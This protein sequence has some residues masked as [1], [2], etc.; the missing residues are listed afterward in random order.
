MRTI[1]LGLRASRG[2]A[3]VVAVDVERDAPHVALSSFIPTATENDRLAS[4]PYHVAAEIA[5]DLSEH[6]FVEAAAAVREGR[7][8]QDTFAA[9]GLRSVVEQ[10][11]DGGFDAVGAAL[12]VNRAGWVTDL[13]R[14]SLA[15][16]EH[17]A[18]AEGL[19]V[20][21]AFRHA[22]RE[23]NV[24]FVEL[25][26]KALPAEAASQL[27]V[28]TAEIDACLKALGSSV[29]RPWRKEHKLAC[30]AAWATAALA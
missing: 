1:T 25:D 4:E 18:V 13:L 8:R 12:L 3:I 19:A 28:S 16:P 14:Y 10:L 29:G 2:G 22:L 24:R 23:N 11:N 9:A 17:P 20:R 6:S 15:T 30:L 21:D 5:R 26:E 27:R 7:K